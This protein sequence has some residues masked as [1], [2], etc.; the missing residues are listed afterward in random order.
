MKDPVVF[1][2]NDRDEIVRVNDAWTRFAL[3]ND[4]PDLIEDR[5]LGTSLWQYLSDSTT[6]LLYL[7]LLRHVRGGHTV[8][9]PLRCDSPAIRRRLEIALRPGPDD[10][11]QFES[12][13][14]DATPR[15]PQPLWSRSRPPSSELVRACSWCKRLEYGPE[16]LEVEAAIV[17]LGLFEDDAPPPEITHGICPDCAREMHALLDFS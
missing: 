17:P 2:I 9:F 12:V 16:W 7:E 11:V 4:A 14:L 5:V 15:P 6:R 1:W 8:R 3:E 10:F 13:L